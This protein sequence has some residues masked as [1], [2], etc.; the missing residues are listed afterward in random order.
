MS[1]GDT[2]IKARIRD[3]W[4]GNPMTYGLN[5][6]ATTFVDEQG[7]TVEV[8]FGSRAFF[9]RADQTFHSW[10]A[11]LHGPEGP[12]TWLFPFERFRG[13][14]ILEVGCGMGCMA[15][16]WAKRGALV[17]AVDLNPVAVAQTRARFAAFGLEGIIREADGE[18]LPF[19]AGS[20]DYVYS[21]GALHHSPAIARSVGELLR[22]LVPGGEA[23]VML[24]HRHSLLHAY[25]IRWV[26]G[27]LNMESR[28]LD[29]VALTSRYS[30]S[31]REEGNPFTWPVTRAEVFDDLFHGYDRLAVKVLGT[32]VPSVLDHLLPRFGSRMLPRPL[33]KALARRWG[34][35]LWIT[36]SKPVPT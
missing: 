21:W 31:G 29:P 19:E 17:T 1:G 8:P 11:P 30:D 22:V 3:W 16:H 26:E 24:Y 15:M 20:F 32:D 36:G 7:R 5:H 14:R 23:G 33:I 25:Q 35:S 10:N 9:E 4:A 6:G 27:F 18:S 13:K 12:F 2:N 28:F 34:W